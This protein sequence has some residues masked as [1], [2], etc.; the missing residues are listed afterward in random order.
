MGPCDFYATMNN[1]V[2]ASF[3][4]FASISEHKFLQVELLRKICAS[5]ILID[6]AKLPFIEIVQT[7]TPTSNV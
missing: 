4:S 3:H 5:V 2:C 7:Y 6:I 1:L